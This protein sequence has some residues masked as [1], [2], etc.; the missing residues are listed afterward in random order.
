MSLLNGHGGPKDENVTSLDEARKRAAQKKKVAARAVGP[1]GHRTARDW[2]IGG[3]FIAM[4]IGL[5]VSMI[6]KYWPAT[7]GGVV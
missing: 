7:V 4:A 2:V 1:S 3:L 6:A 5:I